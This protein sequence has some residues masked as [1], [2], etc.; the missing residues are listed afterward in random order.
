MGER[1]RNYTTT[2]HAKLWSNFPDFFVVVAIFKTKFICVIKKIV[3]L[4][5]FF[6]RIVLLTLCFEEEFSKL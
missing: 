1:S 2:M 6:L 3:C 4:G 5:T